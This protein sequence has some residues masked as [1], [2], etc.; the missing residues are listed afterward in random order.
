MGA[1]EPSRWHSWHCACKIGAT[2][3]A[4]VTVAA[5]GSDAVLLDESAAI[6]GPASV[7]KVPSPSAPM[8]LTQRIGIL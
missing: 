1:M 5:V 3:L 2:S 8:P 4:N 7:S 6:E